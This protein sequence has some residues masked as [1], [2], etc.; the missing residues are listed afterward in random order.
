MFSL[1]FSHGDLS[2]RKGSGVKRRR[3]YRY[4][5]YLTWMNLRDKRSG[6]CILIN[7][8]GQLTW[9]IYRVDK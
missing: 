3:G 1:V 9:T 2:K 7:D 5:C 4:E 8:L 6:V